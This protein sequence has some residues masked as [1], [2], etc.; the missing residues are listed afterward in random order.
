MSRQKDVDAWK[1]IKYAR[2]E[3]KLSQ[4]Q[5]VNDAVETERVRRVQDEQGVVKQRG[6]RRLSLNFMLTS[7]KGP[8]LYYKDLGVLMKPCSLLFQL[9]MMVLWFFIIKVVELFQFY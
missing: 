5:Y 9:M 3:E 4:K 1:K 7:Y 8:Y 2:K 6:A